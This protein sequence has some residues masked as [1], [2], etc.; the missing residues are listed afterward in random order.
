MSRDIREVADLPLPPRQGHIPNPLTPVHPLTPNPN[1]STTPRPI[2]LELPPLTV[3]IGYLD[4]TNYSQGLNNL[5]ECG[6]LFRALLDILVDN[7]LIR[8]YAVVQP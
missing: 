8:T 3:V 4:G 2:Q 7:G 5:D 1:P 6:I